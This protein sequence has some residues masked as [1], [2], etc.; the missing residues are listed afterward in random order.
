MHCARSMHI[1]VTAGRLP[2]APCSPAIAGRVFVKAGGLRSQQHAAQ[3]YRCRDFKPL[4][5]R[6]SK[7]GSPALTAATAHS[8]PMVDCVAPNADATVEVPIAELLHLC[9]N[10]L[11]SLRYTNEQAATTSQV[12]LHLL[13]YGLLNIAANLV[14]AYHITSTLHSTFWQV[15]RCV[16]LN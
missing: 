16:L 10:A 12:Q 3:R 11:K 5:G 13:H 7:A 15:L 2:I 14:S 1:S 8:A 6:P 9:Q 4:I